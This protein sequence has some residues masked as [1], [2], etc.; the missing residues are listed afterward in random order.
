MQEALPMHDVP[1]LEKLYVDLPGLRPKSVRA[2]LLATVI[3]AGAILLRIELDPWLI[4]VQYITLFPS[5]ILITFVCGATVGFYTV[6][7][8]AVS[9]W[10]FLL[11]PALSFR[12]AETAQVYGLVFFV[13]IATI[14]VLIVGTLRAAL[15]RMRNLGTLHVVAFESNPD[16]ILVVDREG[17]I[18]RVNDRTVELFGYPRDALMNQSVE[19][20]LPERL[21]AR[22]TAHRATFFADPQRREMGAGLVLHGRRAD[23]SEFPLGIHLGP[24]DVG[25]EVQVIANVRDLTQTTAI[26]GQ[27]RQAQKMEAIGNLTGGMAHDFNNVLGV[28][29]GNIDMLRDRGKNDPEVAELTHDALEAALKGADLTR[30]LLAFARQQPLQPALV[31]VNELVSGITKLLNRTLGEDIEISV[32]LSK[33]SG[34]TVVD[35]ALLEAGLLNLAN[36]SR[37][38]MPNGGR[39]TVAT[40]NRHLD[41]DYASEHAEVVPGDYVMIEV[42]DTGTGI[43]PDVVPRIFEPFYTTKERDRGTGLG[44]SMVFGFIKQSGGHISVYSELGTGTTFRLYLPRVTEDVSTTDERPTVRLAHGGSETVLAVEDNAALRRILVRQLEELGYRVRQAENAT[45]ALEL[46]SE[47]NFDLLLT[48][49][50]MPGGT[51]GIELAR[52]AR[53]QRPSIRVVFTS[54]FA[55]T[56]VNGLRASLAPDARLLSKPYRKEELALI[57]RDALDA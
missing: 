10:F 45:A 37:D 57:V 6:A 27:L 41:A 48:D 9:A 30:R 14:D 43:S 33:D 23:G 49:I 11:A 1:L 8:A 38:A 22:H 16:A 40:G 50:V 21:R 34:Q 56:Q 36:N 51:D 5:V 53:H 31:D 29:I 52:Q 18:V 12:I 46:M 42:S 32:I 47:E 44:L 4:G 35:P 54:G 24:V 25:G 13:F 17:R 15:A 2:Y 19:M 7:L 28:I 55:E 20:L 3:V 39:L 26:E